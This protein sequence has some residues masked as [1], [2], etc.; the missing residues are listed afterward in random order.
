MGVTRVPLQ[1]ATV[2][3]GSEPEFM[4]NRSQAYEGVIRRSISRRG[5]F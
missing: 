5:G 2:G 3:R 4:G 1:I